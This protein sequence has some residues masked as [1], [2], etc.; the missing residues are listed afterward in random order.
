MPTPRPR[1]HS[2][3]GY[4]KVPRS[5]HQED[6]VALDPKTGSI[7]AMIGGRPDYHDQYNRAVQA[8]RQPGS[9][10]KPFVYTTA[11]DNDYPVT[12]QLLNQPVVLNVQNANGEWEKWMPRNGISFS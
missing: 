2:T 12:T 10:F 7:L 4:P 6:F 5:I 8:A 9:V 3:R 1:P 11:I